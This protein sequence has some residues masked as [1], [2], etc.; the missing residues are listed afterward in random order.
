M[1]RNTRSHLK[2]P[3]LLLGCLATV[4]TVP[5][6][7]AARTQSRTL[8]KV[9]INVSV[10]DKEQTTGLVQHFAL[11]VRKLNSD[12]PETV[13]SSIRI[14]TTSDGSVAL[15]LVPGDYIV[16]SENPLIVNGKAYEWSIRLN[17][18]LGK[19]ASLE[20]NNDNA[21]IT[22]AEAALKRGRIVDE[23]DLLNVLRDGV[24]SVQGE[25]T[26]GTGFI[27]DSS[28]LILTNQHVIARSNELRV[29]FDAGR[30]LAAQLVA[31]D[32]ET[33][34]A[35]LW[36]NLSA[37]PSCK[38][39]AFAEPEAGAN[40]LV[41]GARV[42]T[43][44]SPLDQNKTLT[45]G[46]LIKTEKDAIIADIKLRISNSG[47]PLFNPLGEVVGVLTFVELSGT[48]SEASGVIR[49]ADAQALL[50]RARQVMREA[51]TSPSAE[52][53]P[54]EPQNSYPADALKN[55]LDV[56]KFKSKP[57]VSDMGKYQFTVI[58]PVLKYYITERNRIEL[59]RQQKKNEKN[60]DV[61]A[62]VATNAFRD[63]RNWAD[64]VNRMRPV[65]HLLVIPE[66]SAT[67]KST[68]LSLL[69]LG[70]GAMGGRPMIFPMDYKFKA[71]FKEMSL[72][73]DGKPVIPIQRGKIDFGAGLQSYFKVKAQKAY[74]GVYTYSPETFEPDK[75]KQLNLQVV[76][77]Q[78]STTPETKLID[79]RMVQK[80]WSDFEPYRQQTG[81]Q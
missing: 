31:E 64:Y 67:G 37:C 32:P 58:T 60:A 16:D 19:T 56:K 20:L 15:S 35:V 11:M 24:V 27:V 25:V 72:T 42:F 63:L 41:D 50:A 78:T 18:E 2:T 70:V 80:V 79:S 22:Q 8:V 21:T 65:V 66:V 1:R 51:A 49:I 40:S 55:Q 17:V 43:I 75:C 73:C 14:K 54:T 7:A 5:F 9:V 74:A 45:A 52:L 38:T 71:D 59:A 26:Q 6:S 68:F 57:Y 28:G 13:V 10:K 4:L 61:A 36:V 34:L 30:K 77:E 48:R 23:A 33:D 3:A 47:A 39:L 46:T 69:L 29:Q 53:L 76:S 44:S 81:K 62:A 12:S